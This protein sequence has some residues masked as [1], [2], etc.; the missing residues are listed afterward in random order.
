MAVPDLVLMLASPWPVV[1]LSVAL[2][3]TLTI[4]GVVLGVLRQLVYRPPR[5]PTLEAQELPKLPGRS[6]ASD[7][8]QLTSEPTS[9]ASTSPAPAPAAQP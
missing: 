2:L 6:M 9:P 4:L 1:G 5:K 7:P 8:A 3:L